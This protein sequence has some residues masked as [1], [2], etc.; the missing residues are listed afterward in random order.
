LDAVTTSDGDGS[1]AEVVVI[2]VGG[3]LCMKPNLAQWL[4]HHI[5][6]FLHI[7]AAVAPPFCS[8]AE[9]S[10]EKGA[11]DDASN[12]QGM[13]LLLLKLLVCALLGWED[14]AC[15]AARGLALCFC[16]DMV[17]LSTSSAC[18]LL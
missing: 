3:G 7:N 13:R 15:I 1:V 6:W 2:C 14:G 9:E 11:A 17:A 12:S 8:T 5:S 16:F 10:E 4:L 18:Y